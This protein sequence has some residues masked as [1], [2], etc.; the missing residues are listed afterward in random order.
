MGVDISGWVEIRPPVPASWMNRPEH[1]W[2]YGVVR[3]HDLVHRNHGMLAGLFGVRNGRSGG[4]AEVG[5]FRAIAPGRGD[6]PGASEPYLDERDNYGG[7]VGETWLLWS[8]IAAIDWDEE[9]LIEELTPQLRPERRGDYLR[10]DW[11]TLF[12]LMAVL[13]EQFG[14]NNVRLSVWFDQW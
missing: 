13:A 14:A 10:D 7:Q 8:E 1:G 6:P 4:V 3:I 2:W 5:R 9:G 11:A 12:K